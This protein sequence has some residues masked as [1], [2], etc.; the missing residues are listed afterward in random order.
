MSDK[1]R[2]I[3]C[4]TTY[5]ETKSLKDMPAKF[6]RKYSLTSIHRKAKFIVGYTNFKPQG[7]LATSIR[8]QK[9]PN[10]AGN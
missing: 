8:G 5:L 6:P 9:I 3:F 4:L 1:K 7:H 2:K 10:L